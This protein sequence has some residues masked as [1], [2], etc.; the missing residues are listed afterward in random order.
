MS[1]II[2]LCMIGGLLIII[3]ICL[4]INYEKQKT[5]KAN[6]S[7]AQYVKQLNTQ[8]NPQ[9]RLTQPMQPVKEKDL[10][11]SK[12]MQEA[13]AAKK[14]RELAAKRRAAAIKAAKTRKENEWIAGFKEMTVKD[15]FTLKESK[16]KTDEFTGVYIL[17]NETKDKYYVG[18]AVRVFGRVNQHF[19]GH[20][21]GD[22]YADYK[23]KDEFKVR[24]VPL[25]K[26]GFDSIDKAEKFFIQKF[27]ANTKGYNKT[28]GNN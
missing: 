5:Y 20:G 12:K 24:L 27:N 15:F 25:S 21:N 6:Q 7:T 8:F 2:G 23:Y 4:A 26:S 1:W 28:A 19:T 18:Q 3:F 10:E 13:K 14:K 9:P 17:H 11:W 22:V 16:Q